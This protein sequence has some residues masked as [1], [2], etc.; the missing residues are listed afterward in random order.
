MKK[1]FVLVGFIVLLAGCNST[2]TFNE[3]KSGKANKD[4]RSF[5]ED[6]E[7]QNGTYLYSN[8]DKEIYIF[9]NGI[10]VQQSDE[11]AYFTN[12][13][14]EVDGDRLNV[15]Q[16]VEYTEDYSDDK[17]KSQALYKI[18]PNQ[19]YEEIQAFSNGEEVLFRGVEN[20]K[21]NYV[22]YLGNSFFIAF[23]LNQLKDYSSSC[24][25]T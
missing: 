20:N 16:E 15:F 23:E 4:V 1:L 21:L 6:V 22:S 11:A 25:R 18:R 2:L 17:L 5:L 10:N 19:N 14:V 7:D 24:R 13:D 12:F 9:L 3:I 8:G